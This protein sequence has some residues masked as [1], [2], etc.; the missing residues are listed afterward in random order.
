M[1]VLEK[2]GVLVYRFGLAI[3]LIGVLY[4]Q[5]HY[6]TKETYES[7]KKEF[8]ATQ[9]RISEVLARMEEKNSVNNRQDEK[10]ADH[11]VRIRTLENRR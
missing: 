10:L 6:V 9:T 5:N 4:L 1:R 8:M 2:W 3:C 7:D 11:E